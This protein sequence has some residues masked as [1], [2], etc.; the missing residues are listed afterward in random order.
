MLSG[1]ERV[2]PADIP[3]IAEIERSSFS[4]PWSEQSFAELLAHS[5]MYFGCVREGSDCAAARAVG[6]VVAWFAGGQGEIA[7]LAVDPLA[8]GRGLGAA[9]LDAALDEA[10][11]HRAEEV[12]LEVRCSN[13]RARQLYESRGFVEVGRRRRYYR[14]PVE[15]AIILRW[16]AG[17]PSRPH[18]DVR[19]NK[20]YQEGS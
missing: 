2:T 13:S 6:Y 9:L 11:R 12:F 18:S 19:L 3:A 15:D 1:V 10:R 4:D 17:A 8:R 5:R 7:N 16:T 20:D 14:R